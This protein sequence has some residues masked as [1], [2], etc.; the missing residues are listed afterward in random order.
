MTE[1]GAVPARRR[2][3][4]P[5]LLLDIDG[6][7]NPNGDHAD[8]GFA[9]YTLHGY[10]VQLSPEHGRMLNRLDAEGEL[11]LRWATTW[12]EAAN[13]YVGP[14][15]GLHRDLPVLPID[16]AL[17]GPV[18]FGTNWKAASVLAQTEGVPFAWCDDFLTPGDRVWAEARV[19]DTGTPTLPIR[20]DPEVGLLPDH[21]DQIR[22]WAR[23]TSN[24]EAFDAGDLLRRTPSLAADP[25]ARDRAEWFA[26]TAS[27]LP[28]RAGQ[29]GDALDRGT[30]ITSLWERCGAAITAEYASEPG[31]LRP[32]DEFARQAIRR[33]LRDDGAAARVWADR[34]ALR[35]EQPHQGHRRGDAAVTP[36]PYRLVLPANPGL[37]SGYQLQTLV[38]SAVADLGVNPEW[39]RTHRSVQLGPTSPVIP[40]TIRADRKDTSS[41]LTVSFGHDGRAARVGYDELLRGGPA[42]ALTQL[43]AATGTTLGTAPATRAHPTVK[44]SPSATSEQRQAP[45]EQHRRA[46]AL[47]FPPSQQASRGRR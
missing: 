39:Q 16:R 45:A 13:Q 5:Q 43:A 11:D 21:L 4:K 32:T 22:A 36:S 14:V 23:E 35:A 18:S 19:L 31:S 46:A 44:A 38:D 12:N 37:D 28:A 10:Q 27:A 3:H 47:R 24:P 34:A 33:Y 6:V 30:L 26:R 42:A 9:P 20:I 2:A 41:G 1:T 17:A 8:R 29:G 15:I 40:V 7:L 25:V